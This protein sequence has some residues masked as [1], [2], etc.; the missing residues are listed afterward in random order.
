MKKLEEL[1]N[2]IKE[3]TPYE[4]QKIWE[5]HDTFIYHRVIKKCGKMNSGY[6]VK[7]SI[8]LDRLF[9]LFDLLVTTYLT[10][11]DVCKEIEDYFMKQT[12]LK[13]EPWEYCPRF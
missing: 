13:R 8:E 11:Q 6:L 2:Y 9:E 10:E 4:E 5:G 7:D 12:E 3:H 1:Q